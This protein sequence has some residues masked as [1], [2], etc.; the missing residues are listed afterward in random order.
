MTLN[1]VISPGEKLMSTACFPLVALLY[2][3]AMSSP[4]WSQQRL[5]FKISEG[6]TTDQNQC[7]PLPLYLMT[8]RRIVQLN[9]LIDKITNPSLEPKLHTWSKELLEVDKYSL[10][11]WIH[12]LFGPEWSTCTSPKT[13]LVKTNIYYWTSHSSATLIL[14]GIILQDNT[15]SSDC[16]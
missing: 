16:Y 5:A 7:G 4:F 6:L 10:I 1:L 2:Y 9:N 11:V 12:K 13:I 15:L 8:Q 3:T 14:L